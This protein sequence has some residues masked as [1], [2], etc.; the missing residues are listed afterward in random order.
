[1][2]DIGKSVSDFVPNTL[3]ENYLKNVFRSSQLCS[4]TLYLS[5]CPQTL[6]LS[7]RLLYLIV[8]SHFVLEFKAVKLFPHTI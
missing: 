2:C 5:L 3:D 8:T 4:H 7:F 6:H 1:M